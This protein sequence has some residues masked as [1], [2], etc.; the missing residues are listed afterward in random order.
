MDIVSIFPKFKSSTLL[1]RLSKDGN[2]T[3]IFHKLCDNKGPT[4][5][6]V[7]ANKHYVFGGYNP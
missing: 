1:Y 2:G 5:L 3:R 7:K 4:V 6:F